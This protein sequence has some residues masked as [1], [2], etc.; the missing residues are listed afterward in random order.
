M[1]RRHT[2][3]DSLRLGMYVFAAE[4]SND[5]CAQRPMHFVTLFQK[6]EKEN[7]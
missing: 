4:R 5:Q 1:L 3:R 6:K 7:K 2:G